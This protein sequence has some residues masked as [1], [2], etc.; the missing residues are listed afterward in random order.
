MLLINGTPSALYAALPPRGVAPEP[1]FE[2]SSSR[3]IEAHFFPST[4]SPNIS[5]NR[6]LT[7]TSSFESVSSPSL[8]SVSSAIRERTLD[9]W[10]SRDGRGTEIWH[11]PSYFRLFRTVPI[12][13]NS[14]CFSPGLLFRYRRRYDES[15]RLASTAK[16]IYRGLTTTSSAISC[17][18]IEPT[19]IRD[20][21]YAS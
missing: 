16:T 1:S 7:R 3:V 11:N 21:L 17:N 9:R 12:E 10:T 18:A 2:Q 15:M 19:L 13:L 20:G 8:I 14:T 4:G 6:D 5:A